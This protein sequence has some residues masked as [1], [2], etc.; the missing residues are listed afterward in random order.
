MGWNHRVIEGLSQAIGLCLAHCGRFTGVNNIEVWLANSVKRTA[1]RTAK[2]GSVIFQHIYIQRWI[3]SVWG[4]VFFWN[5]FGDFPFLNITI[6]SSV[7]MYNCAFIHIHTI[8][9]HI[10]FLYGWPTKQSSPRRTLM[11]N[12]SL[13]KRSENCLWSRCWRTRRLIRCGGLRAHRGHE[14][15]RPGIPWAR[16]NR[17]ARKWRKTTCLFFR[18]R[19]WGKFSSGTSWCIFKCLLSQEFWG[20][21]TSFQGLH[22]NGIPIYVFVMLIR[23]PCKL[24]PEGIWKSG[25]RFPW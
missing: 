17:L 10:W 24:F 5:L 11:K 16:T 2:K 4:S 19:L 25:G 3:M 7:F 1:K 18:R 22:G 14:M 23:G 12:T 20:L 6:R 8:Y 13:A 21:N 9:V 15:V